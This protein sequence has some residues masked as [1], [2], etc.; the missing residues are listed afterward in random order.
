ML[1]YGN[2]NFCVGYFQV[3]KIQVELKNKY[4]N[5]QFF[6]IEQHKSCEC[7]CKVNTSFLNLQ[8]LLQS[9]YQLQSSS[10]SILYTKSNQ[11]GNSL[12]VASYLSITACS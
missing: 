7:G 4:D 10:G 8:S 2:Y 3:M 11:T 6:A 12:G 5:T 1:Y 9:D